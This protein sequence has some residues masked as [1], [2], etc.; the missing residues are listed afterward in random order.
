MASEKDFELVDD[1]LANRMPAGDRASFDKQLETDVE[2]KNELNLQK[3]LM[4][5]LQRARVAE[6]KSMLNKI[7]VNNIT[8][9]SSTFITKAALWIGVSA[10][11]GTGLYYILSEKEVNETTSPLTEI[12]E[13]NTTETPTEP[14]T[15]TEKTIINEQKEE[16][17]TNVSETKKPKT[18]AKKQVAVEP[19]IEVFDPST[20]LEEDS[21]EPN[22][23]IL[24]D[25]KIRSI[26]TST[27]AVE[28]DANN[29]K[30]DFHYKLEGD[31]LIL[32]GEFEKNLY[33]ILEFIGEE[34]RTIF[35]YY[36]QNY[37]T[38]KQI[39]KVTSLTPV[40]D[41]VLLKKLREHRAGK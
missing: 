4:E 13:N 15:P 3:G 27:V 35:L 37:Y 30:F 26:S 22:G 6:L 40:K 16:E 11:V 24:V 8:T 28:V 5:G 18:A 7:P 2:L 32:Y 14:A 38:L 31:Q 36:K 1:Y 33:E 23:E 20:E 41:P 17:K 12:T 10:L 34:K 39:D 9:S 29:R 21:K 25:D 19:K